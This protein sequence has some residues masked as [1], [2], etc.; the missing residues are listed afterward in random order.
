[1]DDAQD[2]NEH[3]DH[4]FVTIR[5]GTWGASAL[6]SPQNRNEDSGVMEEYYGSNDKDRGFGEK[7]ESAG[8]MLTHHN[9]AK[10]TS[11]PVYCET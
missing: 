11:S 2:Q 3:H 9:G 10:W 7:L 1:M 4:P 8:E 6:V 5:G